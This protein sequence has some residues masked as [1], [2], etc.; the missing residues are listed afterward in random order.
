MKTSTALA[1]GRVPKVKDPPLLMA[2]KSDKSAESVCD[3][4][5]PFRLFVFQS[6]TTDSHEEQAAAAEA[7]AKDKVRLSPPPTKQQHH[8]HHRGNGGEGMGSY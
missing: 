7:A 6:S 2:T 5:F 3:S 8:H 1:F 4:V